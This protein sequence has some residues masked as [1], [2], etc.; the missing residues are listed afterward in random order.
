MVPL[1]QARVREL[2]LGAQRLHRAGD[3]PGAQ[4][5]YA[6]LAGLLP[7]NADVRHLLGVVA[8]QRGDAV[9]AI[10]HY[11]RALELRPGF[12]QARNN[13]GL[14]LKASGALEEAAQSLEDALAADPGY[15]EAAYNLA[16]L[17]EAR[18]HA[19]MAE[20]AYRR[21][22]AARPD[23]PELLVSFANFLRMQG[24]LEEAEPALRSA[25][26]L[27]PDDP[28]VLGN[29]ALLRI[30]QA[31]YGEAR[32]SAEAAAARAPDA[33]HWWGAAGSAA[34]LMHD[35][36]GAL[37]HLERA[38]ALRPDDG[39][40]WL[41]IGLARQET[42]DYEGAHAA[43]ARAGALAPD[44]PQV[45]W[46]KVAALPAIV[47]DAAHAQAALARFD[48]ELDSLGEF[49]QGNNVSRRPRALEAA[50]SV[51][52]FAL[53]YLSGDPQPRQRRYAALVARVVR[54]AFPWGVERPAPAAA[55]GRRMRVG[56]VS[57]YLRNHV[58]ARFFGA[59]ITG[60]DPARF[61]RHVWFTGEEADARTRQIASAVEHFSHHAGPLEPLARAIRAAA[62]DVLVYPD[63]GLDPRQLAL[64]ALRLA[65]V[66]AALYGHPA[67]SGLESVDYFLSGESLEPADG[68]S[69]YCE[70]LVRLPGLGARPWA[71]QAAGDD[72]WLRTLRRAGRP[73]L[74]CLQNA[75][76]VPP[77]FDAVLAEILER[78]G[79][80]LVFFD[81]G[82]G[83]TRRL[84]TRLE[85]ALARHGVDPGA[86]LHFAPVRPYA[87]YL[88]GIAAADLVLDTPGFSGGGTTLDALGVGAAVLGFEGDCARAR[89]TSAMLRILGLPELVARDAGEYVEHA[90]QLL[91]DAPR[92]ADLRAAIAARAATLLT[93]NEPIHGF[94]QFLR[95]H[96]PA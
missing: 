74:L 6:Q 4:A 87:E 59:S 94:A 3:L 86:A 5:L 82:A 12:V 91:A 63:I 51:L 66:Q 77:E 22:L 13:L 88:G 80:R 47:D 48:A 96:G 31:R 33:A 64:A 41:E 92:L 84:R 72:A 78:T 69:H 62:L 10:T 56:F 2:L 79:A 60:L 71:A 17:Q 16:Q 61:E 42:A 8:Y 26:R 43:L 54:A 21:A 9:G 46:A 44:S 83:L 27:R 35:A 23:W 68:D 81:R 53:H 11:R 50:T 7:D 30:D 1:D 95:D 55:R 93:A 20:A 52:P 70:T 19:Q 38:A 14:A 25:A 73:L 39:D 65:P 37:A 40:L 89:Q 67:S 32:A 75:M 85:R 57:G 24:R 15:A 29:L 34:R 45:R 58:V 76:K 49:L 90:T 28:T 18:G 36:D